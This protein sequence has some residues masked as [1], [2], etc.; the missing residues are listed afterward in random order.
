VRFGRRGFV[1]RR[2][3][4]RRDRALGEPSIPERLPARQLFARCLRKRADRGEGDDA[5]N[6]E[7]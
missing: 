5:E 7:C 4:E 6:N 2:D 3:L 1:A